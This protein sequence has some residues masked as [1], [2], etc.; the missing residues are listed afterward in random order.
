[1]C[2]VLYPFAIGHMIVDIH[3]VS[4][5]IVKERV[6]LIDRHIDEPIMDERISNIEIAW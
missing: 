1:M 3:Q 6:D 4:T 2:R 5:P